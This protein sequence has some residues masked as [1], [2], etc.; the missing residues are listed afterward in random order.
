[1]TMPVDPDA[2]IVDLQAAIKAHLAGDPWFMGIDIFTPDDMDDA[3]RASETP[4][5][6]E[7]RIEQSLSA[8][9][10]GVAIIVAVPALRGIAFDSP[11]V[12]ADNVPVLVRI[13]ENP[14]VNRGAG[15]TRKTYSM[16]GI[17][18]T[19]RLHHFVFRDETSVVLQR[20]GAVPNPDNLVWDVVAR[21]SLNLAVLVET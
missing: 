17:R 6:I 10:K 1:M 14:L 20:S 11:G 21:T 5:D 7:Q 8:L 16:V 13:V 3:G 19:R 9:G 2:I 4:G 15:G 12:L 18:V